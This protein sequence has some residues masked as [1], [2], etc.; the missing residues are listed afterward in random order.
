MQIS[1]GKLKEMRRHPKECL[2]IS[3][4]IWII[5]I[6]YNNMLVY[7]QLKRIL[8][9]VEKPVPYMLTNFRKTTYQKM[10]GAWIVCYVCL[11][12]RVSTSFSTIFF[13]NDWF[14]RRAFA[15]VDDQESAQYIRQLQFACRIQLIKSNEIGTIQSQDTETRQSSY[16]NQFFVNNSLFFS[17]FWRAVGGGWDLKEKKTHSNIY[18][19]LFILT[20]LIYEVT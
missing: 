6:S 11:D 8:R 10:K 13:L 16:K 5:S 1:E 4:L 19:Y 15:I 12:N 20:Q 2:L 7:W 3:H 14:V 17:F 18:F 9:S